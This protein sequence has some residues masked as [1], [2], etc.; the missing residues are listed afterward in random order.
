MSLSGVAK[1]TVQIVERGE[2]H[3]PSGPRVSIAD[4]VARAVQGTRLYAPLE[5]EL[6]HARALE[7]PAGAGRVEVTAETTAE[8]ARRLVEREGEARVVALAPLD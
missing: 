7:A 1:E 4:A 2:Y 3:V 5:L 6:L 8:A